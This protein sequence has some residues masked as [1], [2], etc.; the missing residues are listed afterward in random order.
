MVTFLYCAWTSYSLDN[1]SNPENIFIDIITL[2][3]EHWSQTHNT[4]RDRAS[5]QNN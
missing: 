1:S 3:L 5:N 2:L 4:S